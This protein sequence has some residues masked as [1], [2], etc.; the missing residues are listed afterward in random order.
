MRHS[1]FSGDTF[2]IEDL[3]GQFCL[4]APS[5][6]DLDPRL[7]RYHDHQ[8][9]YLVVLVQC[10]RSSSNQLWYHSG[11]FLV[12]VDTLLCMG[13][14]FEPGQADPKVV[15]QTCK[16]GFFDQTW[17][18]ATG[19]RIMDATNVTCLTARQGDTVKRR[20]RNEVP[21]QRSGLS[22]L[23]ASNMN[24]KR[25]MRSASNDVMRSVGL[26]HCSAASRWRLHDSNADDS[27][28]DICSQ[29]PYTTRRC[30]PAN[31]H[32]AARHTGK[33]VR[34][35]TP[36]YYVSGFFHTYNFENPSDRY[37]RNTGLVS[38]V[39]CCTSDDAS[40]SSSSSEESQGNRE[41]CRTIRWWDDP[42]ATTAL[43]SKGWVLCPRGMY[44]KGMSMTS[45]SNVE[46]NNMI[47]SIE[48]CKSAGGPKVHRHCYQDGTVE[49]LDTTIHSC[50]LEGYFITGVERRNCNSDGV[51]CEEV[52][53]C[54]RG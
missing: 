2:F 30:Y 17:Y 14:V 6:R 18:C 4:A 7:I 20:K 37:D 36:G 51:D 22:Q 33:Y 21:A 53:T 15:L 34:C 47:E 45:S 35:N 40:S 19:N 31:M 49:V 46:N 13:L 1:H 54:C 29:D 10:N 32:Y 38:A 43:I 16:E 11:H 42:F 3:A 26:V 5:T 50:R 39:K 48:C 12:N 9:L 24:T 27:H 41:E 8:S 25:Q 52:L 44:L 23:S 28:E